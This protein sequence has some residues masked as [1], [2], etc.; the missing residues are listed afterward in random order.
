M[1]ARR[2]AWELLCDI[3]LD[4]QYGNLIMR[5]QMEDF[6]TQD[7]ALITQM[8]Y[9]TMEHNQMVRYQWK[10]FVKKMPYDDIAVLLDMSVYQLFFMDKLPAYAVVNEAV[11]IVKNYQ[12]S[13]ANMVNAIL[14]N[15]IRQGLQ[16]PT[17]TTEEVLAIQ[18][19]HPLWIIKMWNAQYGIE[20][21]TSICEANMK[22]QL[23][24]A[25]VNTLKITKEAL[26]ALDEQ[27]VDGTLAK[28][29]LRYLG[30]SLAN[31]NYYK[32]GLLSIQDEASQLVAQWLD[33][34]PEERILDVCSAPG[35]KTCHIAQMM[36]DKGQI[37]AGDIHEHRVKLIQESK[38]RLGIHII[39]ARIM[40]ALELPQLEEQSFDRVL[41]D[42]PCSGYG[43]LGRKSDIKYRMKPEDMDS[44]IP[45]QQQILEKSATMVKPEGILL[46][47]TCT[48]NKK[49]NEKQ[50]E[51]FLKEHEEYVCLQQ[52]TIF[53]Y[54]YNCDGFY[55]AKLQRVR[56]S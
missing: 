9:G 54:E 29:A 10:P 18:T 28:D 8:V 1:K 36:E 43:V 35:T 4:E 2:K 49:E 23:P 55:M 25:R 27:F 56:K 13:Y 12:K 44:L 38:E 11:E 3:C 48:L 5:H 32:E 30:G 20:T 46:Y 15:V 33:A 16:Q 37:I 6:S 51:K 42:V 39:D 26:K 40:D 17:G 52:Q 22:V 31:T 41:C 34:K 50:I 53:P 21:C 19:S 14:H 45:L 7:K 47:S 24:C